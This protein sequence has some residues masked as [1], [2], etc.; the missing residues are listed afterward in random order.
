TDVTL[1]YKG[2][3]LPD[4][5]GNLTKQYADAYQAIILNGLRITDSQLTADS[6]YGARNTYVHLPSATFVVQELGPNLRLCIFQGL[7]L[8]VKQNIDKQLVVNASLIHRILEKYHMGILE[9]FLAMHNIEFRGNT[10]EEIR[11][12]KAKI[13]GLTFT[14]KAIDRFNN[15]MRGKPVSTVY[16]PRHYKIERLVDEYPN[17]TRFRTIE[18]TEET[19][20]GYIYKRYNITLEFPELP[21]VR[22][23]KSKKNPILIPMECLQISLKPQKHRGDLSGYMDTILKQVRKDPHEFFTGIRDMLKTAQIKDVPEASAM[24]EFGVSLDRNMI[25]TEATVLPRP[26]V[27]RFAESPTKKVRIVPVYMANNFDGD[28][29]SISTFIGDLKKQ[30]DELIPQNPGQFSVISLEPEMASFDPKRLLDIYKNYER[31]DQ[32][33]LL[34]IFLPESRLQRDKSRLKFKADLYSQIK[35]LCDTNRNCG[36]PNQCIN[37]GTLRRCLGMNAFVLN[38]VRKIY[39]RLGGKASLINADFD[40][41]PSVN[42]LYVFFCFCT[43]HVKLR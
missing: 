24:K 15:D 18:G 12:R 37:M 23:L 29:G 43:V 2:K 38:I 5:Y 11:R 20:A 35:T 28:K 30:F 39:S 34:L 42:Q 17:T 41:A 10:E 4:R 25:R 36:I 21:L 13:R 16:A 14:K 9:Y 33:T 22:M 32:Y 27:T 3:L 1:E 31:D 8:K 26:D 40:D 7:F 6:F 19:V